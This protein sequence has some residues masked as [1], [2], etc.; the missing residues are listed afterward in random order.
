VGERRGEEQEVVRPGEGRL[1]QRAPLKEKT[2]GLGGRVPG[3]RPGVYFLEEPRP[4]RRRN[5]PRERAESVPRMPKSVEDVSS[6][7]RLRW[8]EKSLCVENKRLPK[9]S[10]RAHP[11]LIVENGV[12][13]G[14]VRCSPPFRS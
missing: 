2:D 13:R 7:V 3:G 9:E 5:P 4:V 10:G 11:A 12:I 14:F 8:S 6:R 1:M